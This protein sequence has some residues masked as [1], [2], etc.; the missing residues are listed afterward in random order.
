MTATTNPATADGR[1]Q[2]SRREIF[3][4]NVPRAFKRGVEETRI[5][6]ERGLLRD[7]RSFISLAGHSILYGIDKVRRREEVYQRDNGQCQ[8]C[9]KFVSPAEAE[10]DHV[11]GGLTGR[12]DC[13]ANLQILCGPCHRLKHVQVQWAKAVSRS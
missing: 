9:R 1:R 3:G 10:M 4:A 6:R 12:C 2:L 5:A 7:S 11:K 8:V 13:A